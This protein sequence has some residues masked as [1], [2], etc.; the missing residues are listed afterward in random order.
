MKHVMVFLVR[1]YQLI[2]SPC[3]PSVCMFT[4]SCSE[5]SAEAY[6]RHGFWRGT[7]LTLARLL[8]CWPWAAGGHDPVP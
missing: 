7:R 2:V 6:R 5:F 8:R 1:G 3:L 4:P